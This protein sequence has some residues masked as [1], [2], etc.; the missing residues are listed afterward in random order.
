[1]TDQY[2]A[3][4]IGTG[5]GGKPLAVALAKAG[6]KTAVIER[7]HVGG[8]CVN[9]GCTP[10][11][12][13][14]ASARVAYLSRRSADYGVDS[15]PVT[16]SMSAVRRRKQKIVDSF[17]D[18]VL[19]NFEKTER[20]ELVKGEARFIGPKSVEILLSNGVTRLLTGERIFINTGASSAKPLV[21]G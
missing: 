10:T 11:K 18:G 19:Q 15:G 20:L 7:D 21:P 17:H 3:I 14:V 4:V 8:T 1:M 2:D 6:W 12:T 13:M 16:V 9:V 5:Q